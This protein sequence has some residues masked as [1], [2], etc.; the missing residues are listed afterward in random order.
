MTQMAADAQILTREELDALLETFAEEQQAREKSPW[1]KGPW[2]GEVHA[3]EE[4][5]VLNPV[6][7]RAME[8]FAAEESKRMSAA[9]QSLIRYDLTGVSQLSSEE[10]AALLF[11]EDLIAE[12]S[13]DPPGETGF[14]LLGRPFFFALF[15]ISLGARVKKAAK[16]FPTHRYT[17]IEERMYERIARELLEQLERSWPREK[18]ARLQLVSIAPAGRIREYPK[19][20]LDVISFDMS[21]FDDILRLRLAVPVEVMQA[22][23]KLKVS[24]ER[25]RSKR[26]VEEVIRGIPVTLKVEIGC[27]E[28]KLSE[29]SRLKEGQIFPLHA[30]DPKLLSVCVDGKEKFRAIRGTVGRRLAVQ[31]AERVRS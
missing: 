20:T 31:I 7:Q 1:P 30:S 15:C 19:R 24:P 4:S 6:F 27:A 3:A 9:Y 26:K 12:F 8:R 18:N 21:G 10:F 16:G 2:S 13:I 29:L 25:T 5:E 28:I 11:A 22:V 17:Q 14:L 23:G